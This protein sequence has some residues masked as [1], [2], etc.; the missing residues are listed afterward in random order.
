LLG[1]VFAEGITGASD[2][3]NGIHVIKKYLTIK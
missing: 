3:G 2:A 1:V